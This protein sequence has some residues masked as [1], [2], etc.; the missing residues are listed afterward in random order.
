MSKN[1][2]TLLWERPEPQPRPAPVALSRESIVRVAIERA[3]AEGLAAVT[4]RS[5]AG[6]LG[7][8]PMRLYGYLKTKD[9]L[10]ALM[11][12]A[13]YSEML[14]EGDAAAGSWRAQVTALAQAMRQ[15]ALRHPWFVALLGGRPHQGPNALAFLEAMLAAVGN[16]PQLEGIDAIFQATKLVNAYILGTVRDEAA[17]AIAVQESGL[18]KAEWQSASWPYLERMIATGRFPM[19]A[20]VVRDVDHLSPEIVFIRGL[21]CVLNGIA[22]PGVG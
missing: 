13:V 19:I 3:D 8:G 17:E 20:K 4:L 12:D 21:D 1:D 9:E 15:A 6:A 11:V 16:A 22:G 5:V 10:L 7:A 2:P 14:T 18:T